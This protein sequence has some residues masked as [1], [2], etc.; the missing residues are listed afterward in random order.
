[1][2]RSRLG[3]RQTRIENPG[4]ED[5]RSSGERLRA[6]SEGADRT[7]TGD[8]CKLTADLPYRARRQSYV[9]QVGFGAQEVP[10]R[11]GN[12]ESAGLPKTRDLLFVRKRRWNH[13]RL[14]SNGWPALFTTPF[15]LLL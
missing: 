5:R 14:D 1:M 2:L 3:T 13:V 6:I 12:E 10:R 7:H 9:R 11:S 8:P 15:E 4:P